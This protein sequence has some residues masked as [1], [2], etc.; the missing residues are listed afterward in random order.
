MLAEEAA[1]TRDEIFEVEFKP[2]GRLELFA[3]EAAP[4][5]Q[6]GMVP[7]VAVD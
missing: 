2:T 1:D 4:P 5:A 6:L 3:P 7:V